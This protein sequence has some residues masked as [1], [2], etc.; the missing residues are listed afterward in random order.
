MA[1]WEKGLLTNTIVAEATRW[2]ERSQRALRRGV[3]N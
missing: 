2:R 3:M 1:S